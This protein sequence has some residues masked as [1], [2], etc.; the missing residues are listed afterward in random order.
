M[1]SKILAV[2][3][4]LDVCPPLQALVLIGCPAFAFP[5]AIVLQCCW[6]SVPYYPGPHLNPVTINPV[7]RMS[8]LGPFFCPRDSE[9]LSEQFRSRSLQPLC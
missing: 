7:I 8:C 1:G 2:L 5:S 6:L 9:A 4:F 3:A